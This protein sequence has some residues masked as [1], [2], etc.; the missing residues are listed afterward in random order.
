MSRRKPLEKTYIDVNVLYYYLTASE[1][2]GEKSKDYISSYS[3]RLVTSALTV[4]LLH[5]LTKLENLTSIL[6]EIGIRLVPL[7]AEILFEAE[8]LKKP[9]DLEDRIHLSTMNYLGIKRIISNDH[10]FDLPGVERV[11]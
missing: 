5:V 2:Y 9:K 1:D 6:E 10:D 8:R 4:W 7:T 3:G 11:F